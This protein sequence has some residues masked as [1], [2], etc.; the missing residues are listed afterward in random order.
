MRNR[1]A[2][3]YAMTLLVGCETLRASSRQ[4]FGEVYVGRTSNRTVTWTNT[5][6]APLTIGGVPITQNPAVFSRGA[7]PALPVVLNQNQNAA[8]PFTFAPTAP[9][10]FTAT[11]QPTLNNAP[12]NTTVTTVTLSGRGLAQISEGD[13]SIGGR[14]LTAP[15]QANTALD[16]GSVRVPG[17]APVVKRFEI[18][19]PFAQ[20]ALNVTVSVVPANQHFTVIQPNASPFQVGPAQP[21]RV[22][23]QFA[24]TAIGEFNAEVRFTAPG[25]HFAATLVKGR[26]TE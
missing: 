26:G 18:S 22:Q 2:W 23:I 14:D 15:L 19:A 25:G 13:L 5:D 10:D 21:V 11:V 12:P 17:G 9:G 16:F 6:Q 4:N 20:N 24:P 3:L 1:A 8:F 7:N